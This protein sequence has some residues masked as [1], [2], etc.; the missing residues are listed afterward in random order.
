MTIDLVAIQHTQADQL[1]P[2]NGR[3]FLNALRDQYDAKIV[4]NVRDILRAYKEAWNGSIEAFYQRV[5][6][7]QEPGGTLSGADQH[8]LIQL[9]RMTATNATA[10][11]S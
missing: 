11:E 2:V 1:A 10:T 3:D 4:K 6:A 7:S 9:V 5:V 8:Y